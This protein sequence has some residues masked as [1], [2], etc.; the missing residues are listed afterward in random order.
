MSAGLYV[1]HTNEMPS[2]RRSVAPGV[3]Q[4]QEPLAKQKQRALTPVRMADV[5]TSR[6]GGTWGHG[7]GR[8]RAGCWRL[9]PLD[10]AGSRQRCFYHGWQAASFTTLHLINSD[11][12]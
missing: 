2:A 5:H 12:C 3:P 9:S 1:R 6:Q 8:A 11:S 4:C 10:M 7:T